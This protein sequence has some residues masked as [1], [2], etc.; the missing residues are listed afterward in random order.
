MGCVF[1]QRVS[2]KNIHAPPSCHCDSGLLE[3]K[4]P[5]AT[6]DPP[7]RTPAQSQIVTAGAG[8]T[9]L[10]QVPRGHRWGLKR[11]EIP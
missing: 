3:S 7:Q 9:A 4:V 8:V 1:D 6:P 5:I 2:M 10:W 11:W